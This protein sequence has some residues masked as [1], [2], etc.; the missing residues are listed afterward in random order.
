ME[1][2]N[3]IVIITLKQETIQVEIINNN[4]IKEIKLN[5]ED[6][7]NN[8]PLTI[9]FNKNEYKICLENKEENSVNKTSEFFKKIPMS[10]QYKI[11]S[12]YF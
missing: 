6:L 9:K 7:T 5:K 11:R 4:K 12:F 2:N 8:Y 3:C 10:T 1:D